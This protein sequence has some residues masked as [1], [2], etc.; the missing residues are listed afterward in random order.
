MATPL[1]SL[2]ERL[3][4]RRSIADWLGRYDDPD[5]AIARLWQTED[6]PLVLRGLLSHAGQLVPRRLPLD[7]LRERAPPTVEQ[8]TQQR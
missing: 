6:D 4:R 3:A 1:A 2:L 5:A 7:A 8:L